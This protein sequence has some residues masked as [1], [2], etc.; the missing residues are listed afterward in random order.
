[1]ARFVLPAW[2]PVAKRT[3]GAV[4]LGHLSQQHP[5]EVGHY[6]D[7]MRG[8]EEIGEVAAQAYVVVV[9]A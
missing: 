5:T 3:D 8:S 1:M 7:Q 6:L 2:L 9:E 4:L